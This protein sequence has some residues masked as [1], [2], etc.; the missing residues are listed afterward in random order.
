[1]LGSDDVDVVD[2]RESDPALVQSILDYG[3]L[4]V[5][6]PQRAETLSERIADSPGEPDTES[7]RKRFET[8]LS[9]VD[10]HLA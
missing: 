5:G 9:R 7:P 6:T 2:L 8:A 4:I 10:D 3:V 1:V